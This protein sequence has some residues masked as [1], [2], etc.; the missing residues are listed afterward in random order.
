MDTEGR[1]SYNHTTPLLSPFY[2]RGQPRFQLVRNRSWSQMI[3]EPILLTTSA[4]ETQSRLIDKNMVMSLPVH[5]LMYLS[6][7]RCK[8]RKILPILQ[9]RKLR[10]R[11]R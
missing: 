1:E 7:A 10:F 4:P 2:R 9:Q 3:L 6:Q 11:E 8:G 5:Y